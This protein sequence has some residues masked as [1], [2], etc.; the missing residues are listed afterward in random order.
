MDTV[1]LPPELRC[2][3][4]TS[5]GVLGWKADTLLQDLTVRLDFVDKHA[6][7]AAYLFHPLLNPGSGVVWTILKESGW[8]GM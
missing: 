8:T 6:P 2:F 3:Q 5:T 1:L 4:W 7:Q